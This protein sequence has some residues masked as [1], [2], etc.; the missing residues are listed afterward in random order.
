MNHRPISTNYSSLRSSIPICMVDDHES[1]L[2]VSTL[3]LRDAGFTVFG[4]RYPEVAFRGVQTGSFRVVL[5]DVVMPGIDGFTFLDRA[6]QLDPAL[7]V[8]LIT[9]FYSDAEATIAKERGA[10][11]YLPKPLDW[12]LVFSILDRIAGVEATRA[13]GRTTE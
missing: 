11:D 3:L 4:T 12:P 13:Q 6:L 8:I 7:K 2:K 5:V 9:G 10:S 1:L